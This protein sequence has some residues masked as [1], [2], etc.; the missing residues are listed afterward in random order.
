MFFSVIAHTVITLNF[1]LP[2]SNTA[3]VRGGE[4]QAAVK[5]AEADDKKPNGCCARVGKALLSFGS[6]WGRFWS[7]CFPNGCCGGRACADGLLQFWVWAG[8][9]STAFIGMWAYTVYQQAVCEQGGTCSDADGPVARGT[10]TTCTH[11]HV[12]R[13][14]PQS[15]CQP[16]MVEHQ[17]VLVFSLSSFSLYSFG[18]FVQALCLK[19]R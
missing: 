8:M 12:P 13:I 16:S 11:T 15:R 1:N 4:P 3:A 6:A 7:T 10:H 17:L 19:P 2:Y 14:G 5:A 9:V 18:V